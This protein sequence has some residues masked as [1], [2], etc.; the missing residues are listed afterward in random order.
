MRRFP[1]KIFSRMAFENWL[2]KIAIKFSLLVILYFGL[3]SS[4]ILIFLPLKL[5]RQATKAI[6][7]KAQSIARMTA[8]S[9]SPALF[10][11]D[12]TS[13]Q[14]DILSVLQTKD[15]AYVVVLDNSGNIVADH[16]LQS[17]SQAS[18]KELSELNR[19]SADGTI[20]KVMAPILANH[21]E[22]GRLYLGASLQEVSEEVVR[23]RNTVILITLIVFVIGTITVFSISS[24]VT[25]PL[26]RMVKIVHQVAE[27]D[28]TQRVAI[29]SRD[30][31]G[32]LAQSFNIM[33]A[34]LEEYTRELK[35]EITQRKQAEDRV[36]KLN[37]EL[38]GRVKD[39]TSQLE[40]AN[41][42]LEG[43]VYSVSH[44]LRAPIR[45]IVGF[46]DLLKKRV[47]STVDETSQR[48]LNN[49][50]AATTKL[51]KLIDDLLV[52]SRI[53]RAETHK[54]SVDL[55]QIIT[56]VQRELKPDF[57]GRKIVW[58]I[59]KLKM[60]HGDPTLLHQVMIN[61]IA[62]A[63]KFTR[64]RTE[65]RI[66]IGTIKNDANETVVFI[67]DNGVGFDMKYI[68]KLFGVFQRLHHAD[69]FE[70]TGIG[71]ANV[72]RIIE[73][74]GGRVWAEAVIDEGA[75]FYFALP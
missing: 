72:K 11:D 73:L 46:V 54:I 30:E 13:I 38:E 8:F 69:D 25:R 43:F 17:A 24:I 35:Q 49:I 10:F 5:E 74:H 20:F 55:N 60:I 53:G 68:D 59:D 66:E 28:L 56:E 48:F 58:K 50:S 21:N 12:T 52:F 41:K 64:P 39:R 4:F 9:M 2:S 57:E 75:T 3:V 34:E 33:V 70:G 71:L 26:G 44:D 47:F 19:K 6:A 37:D 65:A 27:G 40:A 7:E 22:I 32:N 61:L 23:S 67:R 16:N 42:E 14:K 45:H 51:G 18:F 63:I 15:I 31:V 36:N 1:L 62:N 29:S